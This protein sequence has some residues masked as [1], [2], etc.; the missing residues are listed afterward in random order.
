MKPQ[1]KTEKVKIEYKGKVV[2]AK[3]LT[4]SSIINISSKDAWDI[5]KKSELLEFIT[6]G[7]IK[8]KPIG[9]SFPEE[10]KE[11]STEIAKM[12]LY[13]FIPLGKHYLY[14]DKM[15]NEKMILSSKEKDKFAKVWNHNIFIKE[16]DDETIKYTDEITI[17]G[18]IF[19]SFITIFSK[20][21]YKHRQKRWKLVKDRFFKK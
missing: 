3:R 2:N 6:K 18:G 7:K 10:W 11:K 8:F 19:T 4:I 13:G 20:S 9:G 17:Y 15:D 16:I 14:L 1:V 12:Y 5:V 21:F